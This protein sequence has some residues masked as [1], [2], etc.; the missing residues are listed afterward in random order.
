MDTGQSP[1]AVGVE[2]R[3]PQ[4]VLSIRWIDPSVEPDPA[5]WPAPTEWRTQL[6]QPIK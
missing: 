1:E 2:D 4:P 5:A 6:V 3:E